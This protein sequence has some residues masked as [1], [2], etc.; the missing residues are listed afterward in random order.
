M[1]N[2]CFNNL[3]VSGPSADLQ[4]FLK[5][6]QGE[7]SAGN[8]LPLDFNQIVPQTPEV[9]AS[10][11]HKARAAGNLP[12]WY[13]W[14]CNNW[15]TKWNLDNDTELDAGD[16]WAIFRFDTAWSPPIPFVERASEMFPTLEFQLEYNEPGNNI[17]GM[18]RY[19]DGVASP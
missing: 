4:R 14:R 1:P 11:E 19:R 3:H 17:G 18:V 6:V 15:G 13:E 12:D 8:S 10:L 2:W 16:D 5:T 9:L 7:D